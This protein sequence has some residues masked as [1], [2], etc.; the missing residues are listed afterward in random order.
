MESIW[1]SGD[2]GQI[3]KGDQL[4]PGTR[5]MRIVDPSQMRVNAV[6]NQA[7]VAFLR[8][9]QKA[10]VS[11]DAVSGAYAGCTRRE[12]SACY[13]HRILSRRL[14]PNGS[15]APSSRSKRSKG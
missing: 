5:Y 6:V 9:G 3:K 11:F 1:R 14:R 13:K 15:C 12:R 7:D 4:R 2:R 10:R 8:V